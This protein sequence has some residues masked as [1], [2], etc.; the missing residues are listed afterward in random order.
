MGNWIPGDPTLVAQILKISSSY[1]PPPPDGFVS[2]MTW[3]IAEHV[4]ERFAAAGVPEANITLERD[5]FVFEQPTP[6][7]EFLAAFRTYYGPT[8]NAFEAAEAKGQADELQARARGA[9]QR[10]EPGRERPVDLDPGDVPA[11]DRRAIAESEEVAAPVRFRRTP[12]R[13]CSCAESRHDDARRSRE[14]SIRTA[15]PCRTCRTGARSTSPSTATR[16][17]GSRATP[18]IPRRHRS[19]TTSSTGSRSEA[20]VRRPAVRRGWLE[21]GPGP[22]ERRGADEFV[23]LEWAEALDLVAA[24]LQRVRTAA[25][26]RGDLRRV[27]RLGECRPVP[28]RAE[29]A[30]PL[31]Q[32]HRRLHEVGQHLLERRVRGDPAARRR[33]RRHARGVLPGHDVERDRGPHRPRRRVRRH[34]PE[35][36]GGELRWDRPSHAAD[37]PQRSRS[38]RAHVRAVQPAANRPTSRRRRRRGIAV[39]PGTDT[40]VMLALAH[41]LVTEGLHD[42][43]FLDRYCVG[44][45]RLIAYVLGEVDGQ[46]KD[47]GVGGEACRTSRRT[48]SATSR[49]AWRRAG[50]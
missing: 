5:T 50:R 34:E 37:A 3:G 25:R 6:P 44:A 35:E 18:T 42:T 47:P 27:V 45:D 9:L 40:A 20:R 29:S 2:P 26:Q 15:G 43:D 22:D 19:S 24:E 23:E 46:P 16:S 39:V 1:S 33:H 32:L 8:M 28:P 21:H 30:A 41:V 38:A 17:S 14:L 49:A 36:R 12:E 13:A 10:A 31:P 11:G 7:A 48:P 4:I